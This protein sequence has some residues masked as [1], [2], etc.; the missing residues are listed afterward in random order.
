MATVASSSACKH[1]QVLV[2]VFTGGTC[3]RARLPEAE[4]Q[5]TKIKAYIL[6]ASPPATAKRQQNTKKTPDESADITELPGL[7]F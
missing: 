4:I 2:A 7:R 6:D 1:I 3:G 5:K